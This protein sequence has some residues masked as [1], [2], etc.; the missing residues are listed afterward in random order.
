[1]WLKKVCVLQERYGRWELKNFTTGG[2]RDRIVVS[3]HAYH[4]NAT[5][6]NQS[7]WPS[8]VNNNRTFYLTVVSVFFF[9]LSSLL[10]IVLRYCNLHNNLALNF[11]I[12]S[13][14]EYYKTSIILRKPEGRLYNY[15]RLLIW[16][17][18]R[19]SAVINVWNLYIKLTTCFLFNLMVFR[20]S[21]DT[22]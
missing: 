14:L 6:N 8:H 16:W 15:L 2:Q 9:W 19:F 17:L 5:V 11:I 12:Y 22:Y 20:L 1:M 10:I 18:I 13:I 7:L 21:L 3:S 4:S